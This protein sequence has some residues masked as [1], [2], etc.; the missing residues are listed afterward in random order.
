[1][2]HESGIHRI[3]GCIMPLSLHPGHPDHEELREPH[4]E[5]TSDDQEATIS[6]VLEIVWS[7]SEKQ[8]AKVRLILNDWLNLDNL[9]DF[10]DEYGLSLLQYKMAMSRLC[11]RHL[12]TERL[13]D[14]SRRQELVEQAVGV[15]KQQLASRQQQQRPQLRLE[16]SEP[17]PSSHHPGIPD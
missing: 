10:H 12:T 8:E 17:Q 14:H 3:G 4:T 6:A 13:A 1:M 5:K 7:C 16:V 15:W 9:V 2:P 11:G